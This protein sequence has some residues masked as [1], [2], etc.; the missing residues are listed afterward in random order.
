VIVRQGTAGLVLVGTIV[1]PDTVLDGEVLIAGE[2]IQCVAASCA[3]LPTS[4]TATI[5]QTNGIIFPGLIDTHNHI[6]FDIFDETDWAPE[7]SDNFTNHD[8]WP[9]RKRYKA[10]VDAKQYLNGEG[11]SPANVGCE[12]VKY[13]EL[14]GVIAGTTSILGAAIIGDKKCYGSIART[15]DQRPNG[16]SADKVQAATLFPRDAAEADKICAN[17]DTGKTDA[18][19]IHIGEG[20]DQKS[21]DEFQKLFDITTTNGCLFSPKTSIVHGTALQDAQ[22]TRMAAAGMGLVWSPR[23]NVFLYGHGTDLTKTTTIPAA[24]ERGI[25]VALAP[26][27]SIGGSQNLL[28]E[29]R[30]A[31]R[32]DNMQWGN[33]LTPKALVQMA[34]KNPA[35]LLGLATVL[36][37]LAPGRKGDVAVV[38]GDRSRPYDSILAATPKD[39]RLVLVGGKVLYG[40]ASVRPLGQATPDCDAV[41]VC[42][43]RKFACV[44]QPG[45]TVAD[46]LGD[47]YEVIKDR[48]VS[49]LKKYDDKNLTEWDFSPIAPLVKCP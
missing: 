27:W 47:T 22:F 30:F 29:L 39:V 49:E 42:G 15:I 6:Q 37:E 32:V 25:T 18:Y 19:L 35:K 13:G 5:V 11:G 12:L 10:M 43:A 26:D 46:K 45:G 21:R 17:F 4:A 48:L 34:T 8:Q 40:D 41:D 9:A 24:V 28:D 16:L 38:S 7:A 1:T 33:V 36:G 20:V 3:S 2:D 31:D 23:S 14:K 44:A